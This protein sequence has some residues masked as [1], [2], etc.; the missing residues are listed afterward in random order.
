MKRN[1]GFSLLE[2]IVVVAVLAV[3]SSI[4][5]VAV[6]NTGSWK[7][8]EAT[9]L[10]KASMGETKTESMSKSMASLTISKDA[11]G[12]YFIQ[13]TGKEKEKL[14]NKNV[15]IS[16]IV[17][18]AVVETVIESGSPLRF[19]FSRSSGAF[20]PI[21]DGVNVDGSYQYHTVNLGGTSVP[22]Y[23][24]IIIISS[25]SKSNKIILVKDTGKYY[26][27]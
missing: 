4:T 6:V 23:C 17:E 9:D 12:T 24:S 14:A 25:G 18:G 13:R 19:S 10:L 20:T 26:V 1:K 27:E 16:Y 21:I 8:R 11:S 22:V 3:F 15:T 2:L 7:V 5:I